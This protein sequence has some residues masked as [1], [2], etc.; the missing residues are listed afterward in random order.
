MAH[1]ESYLNSI[2]V[3]CK[4]HGECLLVLNKLLEYGASFN[5]RKCLRKEFM[6]EVYISDLT[7]NNILTKRSREKLQIQLEACE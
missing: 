6:A 3:I 1:V 5:V 4:R 7:W 2:A